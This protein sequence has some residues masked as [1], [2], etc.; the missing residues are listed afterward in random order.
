VAN[1]PACARLA[2]GVYVAGVNRVGME[3]G[4]V[5]GT[6]RPSGHRVLGS[7]FLADPFGRIIAK[8]SHD[9][10]EILIG[11]IDL[12][13]IEETRRNWPFC[14]TAAST[15]RAIT[16]RFLDPVAAC[17]GRGF[18][19]ECLL[20]AENTPRQLGYALPP[21]GNRMKQLGWPGRTIPKTAGKVSAIPW[22]YAEI[23]RLLSVHELVHLIVE[24]PRRTARAWNPGAGGANLDR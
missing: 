15:L 17:G 9:A 18:R 5:L 20:H 22:L 2:N 4:D 6:V 13:L 21:N 10:E 7:S 11:E 3:H 14:A 16:K 19:V 8:A 12:G 23:V 1:H 24:A